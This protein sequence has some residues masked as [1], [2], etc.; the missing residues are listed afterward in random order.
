MGGSE[1]LSTAVQPVAGTLSADRPA[2][3]K[4]P[5]SRR[6][7]AHGFLLLL[8]LATRIPVMGN[9]EGEPDTARYITGL[10]LWVTGDRANPLIYA[11]TMSAGYYWLA[12]QIA[13][14]THTP[15]AHYALM[16]GI[17][18]LCASLIMSVVVFELSRY[19]TDDFSS[20]VCT[21]LF[22]I[23][24]AIWWSG[25]QA[26]P[27]ALSIA[28][29]LIAILAY[30]KAV[31]LSRS[32]A[33]Y[34]VA[35]F[36][37]SA[38]LL[39][40]IDAVLLFPAFFGLLVFFSEDRIP[41][42]SHVVATL[43]L[44]AATSLI[45]IGARAVILGTT[46]RAVQA[47]T[48]SSVG[49]YLFLPNVVGT[50]K[51]LVPVVLAAGPILFAFASIGTLLLLRDGMRRRRLQWAF[52]LVMW[53]VPGIM[54]WFFI[55]WNNP[56]HVA[57]FTLALLWVGVTGW[58]SRFGWR[59]TAALAIL[60]AVLNVWSVPA[61]SS[62]SFL[63]SPNVPASVRAIRARQDEIRS[64]AKTMTGQSGMSCFIGTYTIPYLRL[65]ALE[66]NPSMSTVTGD[67]SRGSFINAP[68]YTIKTE[69]VR[70]APK[71]DTSCPEGYSVEYTPAGQKRRFF[72][73]EVYS[74]PFWAAITTKATGNQ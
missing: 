12:A 34:V 7:I 45:F 1:N 48:N 67:D 56:R 27:Q 44:L 15:L 11:K 25:I 5:K 16:L 74:S 21:G 49:V 51:Q 54:F 2:S 43:A 62:T 3:S 72:G 13:T 47:E 37:M 50:I 10:H 19:I 8:V 9:F 61:N 26:H 17:M 40:K 29:S 39:M 59:I 53:C 38:A 24:P 22:L 6:A 42:I 71:S 66:E 68:S 64:V 28:L 60:A 58:C 20:F 14:V 57:V 32:P 23:S 55:F 52:L 36:A 65:Y 33:L 63:L 69:Y 35:V 18:S 70:G 41:K 73:K 46:L 4:W 30:L 31:V